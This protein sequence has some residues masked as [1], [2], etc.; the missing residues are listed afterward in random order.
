VR[1][2]VCTTAPRM[3][4]WSPLA[5]ASRP[6]KNLCFFWFCP[7]YSGAAAARS[8]AARAYLCCDLWRNAPQ[9]ATAHRGVRMT[10]CSDGRSGTVMVI[11]LPVRG[12][13]RVMVIRTS[14]SQLPAYVQCATSEERALCPG[15]LICLGSF[16]AER[17]VSAKPHLLLPYAGSGARAPMHAATPVRHRSTSAPLTITA[18]RATA[19]RGCS[20]YD[21]IQKPAASRPP[22]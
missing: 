6:G 11:G 13:N 3:S 8:Y 10:Y 16:A 9:P 20:H 21:A 5:A 17:W 15:K 1:H 18:P 12:S 22:Q 14:T 4:P 7:V 19:R 2:K